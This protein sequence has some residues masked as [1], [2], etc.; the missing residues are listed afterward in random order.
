[1]RGLARL[2]HRG[3]LESS[4]AARPLPPYI[5]VVTWPFA[6]LLFLLTVIG[7][8]GFAYAAHRWIMHGPGWFLHASHHRPRSGNW[9]LNDLYAAIF[10]VPSIVLILGG[11]QLGWWPGC[12]WIGAGIA[13]YGAIYFGF[14]DVI[15]HGRLPYRYVARSPYMKR[16]VQAHRLHHVVETKHGTVSFGFLLAPRPDALKAE[17][18]RRGRAGVRG[19]SLAEK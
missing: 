17:L 12:T 9:E 13:A 15:V 7:M 8:E 19:A 16:I 5:R 14:H 6:T 18:K 1:M 10:A 2:K 3:G 11:V 4:M